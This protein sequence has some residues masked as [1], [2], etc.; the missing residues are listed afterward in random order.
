[1]NTRMFT[2][3]VIFLLSA[4]VFVAC[5]ATDPLAGTSWQLT[6]I[7]DTPV[8]TEVVATMTFA[9]G[10]IGGSTGC[11]S[12]GGGYTVKGFGITFEQIFMTQMACMGAP[13]EVERN[14]VQALNQVDSYTL[15]TE[16]DGSAQLQLQNDPSG[17]ILTLVEQTP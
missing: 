15:T 16:A 14:F 4:W 11:N 6:H 13:D 9:D 10:N 8:P 3:W 17:V 12:Y 7:N 2:S 1:M 5:S